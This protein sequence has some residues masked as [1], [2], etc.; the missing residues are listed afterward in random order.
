M[1]KKVV[2][3]LIFF[4]KVKFEVPGRPI[5]KGRPRFVRIGKYVRT[6]TPKDTIE[7]ENKIKKS[8]L[9][10][11]GDIKLNGPLCID[12]KAYYEPPK[13]ISNKRK[14]IMVNDNEILYTK[15]PDIDNIAK[16]VLDGLN[17]IAFDDDAQVVKMTVEK[18]Y[19]NKSKVSITLEENYK[20]KR[21]V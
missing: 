15:K 11:I 20:F 3:P 2:D 14:N 9:S 16:S 1:K 12:I 7:Y 13:S 19:S 10:N 18:H 21:E 6:Y 8:Y 5:G 4:R 17:S